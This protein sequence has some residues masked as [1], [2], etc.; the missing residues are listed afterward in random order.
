MG[1]ID[2]GVKCSVSGCGKDAVRSLSTEKA[3]FAGLNVGSGPKRAYLCREH[4]KEFK[5]KTK[6]DKTIDKWRYGA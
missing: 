6:K 5:K 2:K 1:R 4:Y 3:K